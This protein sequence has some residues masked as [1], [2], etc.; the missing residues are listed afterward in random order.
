MCA[1]NSSGVWAHNRA[2]EIR[3]N[4]RKKMETRN[5]GEKDY[6]EK[7]ETKKFKKY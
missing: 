3:K 4:K 1:V 2:G 6:E 7:K 5:E